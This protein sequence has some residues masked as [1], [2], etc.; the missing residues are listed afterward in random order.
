MGLLFD[1]DPERETAIVPMNPRLSAITGPLK[2]TVIELSGD[3]LSIGREPSNDLVVNDLSVSRRHCII[4]TEEG[5]IKVTDLDSHNGTF[6]NDTPIRNHVLSHGDQLKVGNSLF[7]FLLHDIQTSSLLPTVELGDEEVLTESAVHF[8]VD[9]VLQVLAR[10]LSAFVKISQLINSSRSLEAVQLQLLSSLFE[11]VPAERAAILLVPEDL[12]EQLL[13]FGRSRIVTCTEP[14]R[15]SRTIVQKV[16]ADGVALLANDLVKDKILGQVESLSA[17]QTSSVMCVPLN[18]NQQRLGAIYLDSASATT[19]F[20]E[21]DLQ[22]VSAMANIAAATLQNV[23]HIESLQSENQRLRADVTVAHKMIGESQ[24]MQKVYKLIG[25]VAQTDSTVLIR[26]ESGTGKEL[27]AH[28]I[29]ANSDRSDKAFVA[30]N[31]AALTETLLESELF[32]YERGAFTGATAQKK[33]KLE[34]ADGGTVFLDEVGEMVLSLQVKLLRVLQER[35]F[36]RV[37]GTRPI[38][39]DIRL[40]AATNRNLE[41][42]VKQGVF[43][44]DLYYRL[45]VVTLDMPPLRER[46]EDI[47]LLASYFAAK[48]A[49]TCKRQLKGISLEARGCLARYDWPGNVRELEN[50]I[51]RAVVLGAT[52]FILP[53]DLPETILETGAVAGGS[54]TN[55]HEG[56]NEAKKQVILRAIQL[57]DGNYTKAAQLLG[58]H[59]NNLHRLIRKMNLK[60]FLKK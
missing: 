12:N 2:S 20:S 17:V 10:D 51:E 37:G 16:L 50:T 56:V 53:E 42:A 39:V 48:F 40:I 59:P 32:G 18:F 60:E 24:P 28:A 30:I 58:L 43:R 38:K 54:L 55:Y 3:S 52:P 5:Q 8:N 46:S 31:C 44:K 27:T 29:H 14:V 25:K 15:V 9:E 41:E 22:L 4:K 34:I 7:L 1:R 57:A 26:G 19:R 13:T 49:Q 33:G 35:E 23:R 11:L 45:N 21:A 6:V 47:Q 36:E